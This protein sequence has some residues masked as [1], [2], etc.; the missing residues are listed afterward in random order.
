MMASAAASPS[1]RLCDV[2]HL[3]Q[4]LAGNRIAA[5]KLARMFGPGKTALLDAALQDGDWI[6]LRRVVHALR[7]SCEMFS[8]T[9]CR[10]LAGKLEDTLPAHVDLELLEDCARFKT[11]LADVAAELHAFLE[12]RHDFSH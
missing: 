7:A 4:S 10:A 3:L 1:Y 12:D 2:D 11:V 6:S 5:R 9:V 8:T